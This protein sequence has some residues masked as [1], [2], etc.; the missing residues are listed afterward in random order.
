[1]HANSRAME[2]L[3]PVFSVYGQ[4]FLLHQRCACHII[5]L[6]VKTGFK[7]VSTHIDSV[8]EAISWLFASNPRVAKWKRFCDASGMKPRKFRTDTD[9]RWNTTYLMLRHVL[10]YK[11][12]LTVFLQSNNATNSDGQLIMSSQLGM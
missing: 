6:I 9:H 8:R 12:L 10:P 4:S 7:R 2:I 3:Q 1:M 5:N 11:D